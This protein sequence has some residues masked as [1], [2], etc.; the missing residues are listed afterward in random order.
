MLRMIASGCQSKAPDASRHPTP[1]C[2]Y[3]LRDP[4]LA[5]CCPWA[6]R[7]SPS[8]NCRR[9]ALITRWAAAAT[10]QSPPCGGRNTPPDP[11]CTPFICLS[12]SGRLRLRRRGRS[13]SL[14][15]CLAMGAR[16]VAEA[17]DSCA[18][19]YNNAHLCAQPDVTPFPFASAQSLSAAPP[20]SSCNR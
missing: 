10:L 20:R 14:R 17:S 11:Q 12:V 13:R 3:D 9:C 18:K 2:P 4:A 5:P 7:L 8:V 1:L 19:R 15:P 16:M 6:R